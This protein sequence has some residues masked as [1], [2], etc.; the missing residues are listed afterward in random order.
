MNSEL[1]E[2]VGKVPQL[3]YAGS[4][5]TATLL[6]DV[7]FPEARQLL[8]VEE[9]EHVFRQTPHLTDLWLERSRDQRLAGGWG[10]EK[11]TGGYRVQNYSGGKGFVVADRCKACAEFASRYVGFIGDVLAKWR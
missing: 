4:K 8:S 10:I 3:Y 1:A 11:E 7:G 2:Q 9:L 5:S 6:K